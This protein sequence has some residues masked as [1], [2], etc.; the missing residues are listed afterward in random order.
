M[1]EDFLT[2]DR[3]TILENNVLDLGAVRV[4]GCTLWSDAK[5]QTQASMA[6][7]LP[8]YSRSVLPDGELLGF[9]DT[10][11]A[12]LRSVEFLDTELRKPFV[13]KTIVMTHHAPS[14]MSVNERFK[15]GR[16]SSIAGFFATDLEWMIKRYK[17]DLW[18]HGHTHDKVAYQIGD[19]Q[20][21]CNPMGN[22]G[23][24]AYAPEIVII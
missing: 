5:N 21:I 22:E 18:V 7:V 1:V 20:I 12:H 14:F 16:A 9:E 10:L 23:N 17:P 19:T 15:T 24:E 13:G 11:M 2:D 4:L 8:E 3:V 6:S